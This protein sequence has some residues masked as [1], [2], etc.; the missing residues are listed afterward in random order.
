MARSIGRYRRGT[1]LLTLAASL[2]SF[3]GAAPAQGTLSYYFAHIASAGV[4]R[5]TFTYVNQTSLPITCNT[6]FYSDSGSP[7]PLS[8][9]GASLSSTSD[10]IPAGGTARR[11]TDAQTTQA[12]VTGW[13]AAISVCRCWATTTSPPTAT[14]FE[15]SV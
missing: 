11:Q 14:T 4:W 7:L 15:S 2:A 3:E 8:F 13:Q 1:L 9:N 6:S 12:T 5:T 10:T